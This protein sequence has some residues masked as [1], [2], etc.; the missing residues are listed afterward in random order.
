MSETYAVQYSH[1]GVEWISLK[2][3]GVGQIRGTDRFADVTDAFIL[4]GKEMQCDPDIA[5]RIVR[6]VEEVV[7]APSTLKAREES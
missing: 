2:R 4:L 6:F 3:M 7:I 1:D 5:H